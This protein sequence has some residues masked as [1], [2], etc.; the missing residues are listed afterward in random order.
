VSQNAVIAPQRAW[1]SQRSQR[2]KKAPG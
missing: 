1:R 2:P